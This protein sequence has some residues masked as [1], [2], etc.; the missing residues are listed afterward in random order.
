M[1]TSTNA[2]DAESMTG[3]RGVRIW[4]RR[5]RVREAVV[6]HERAKVGD[7]HQH[8]VERGLAELALEHD[9]AVDD[10]PVAQRCRALGELDR[11][12]HAHLGQECAEEHG[13][14]PGTR[15]A[16]SRLSHTPIV[17]ATR[18]RLP[19]LARQ[20]VQHQDRLAF[21]QADGDQPMAQVIAPAL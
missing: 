21:G 20:H 9:H 10:R 3:Y 5:G 15:P 13:D 17:R 16:S 11:V 1:T 2:S 19:K 6:Q 8:E 7:A 12:V 14:R 4:P 18:P